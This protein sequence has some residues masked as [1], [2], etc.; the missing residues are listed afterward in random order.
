[1]DQCQVEIVLSNLGNKEISKKS[2][3]IRNNLNIKCIL[4][5]RKEYKILQYAG[6]TV[7]L[8][9]GLKYH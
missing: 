4:I 8:L 1:M 5:K 6:D 9:D 3:T 2:K 7:L